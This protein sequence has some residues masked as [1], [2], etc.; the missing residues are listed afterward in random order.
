MSA[1]SNYLENELLDHV[2]GGAAYTAPA[3][4]YFAAHTADPTDAG[5]GTEVS[6]N[7]YA[8]VS[9]TNN[10]TNFPAAS[11]GS[12]TNATAVA[13]PEASGSWGTITHVGVWD[14]STTGNLLMHA[15]LDASK[16]IGAADTLSFAIGGLT[17]IMA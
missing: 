16:A 12:K 13:F 6:G 7:N 8:R 10:A 3:T 2:I 17:F 11:A 15:A 4:L 5:S 14:A 9:Q 1:L